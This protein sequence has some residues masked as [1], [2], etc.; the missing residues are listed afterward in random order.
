MTDDG[1]NWF[2]ELKQFAMGR[3]AKYPIVD[4]DELSA[5]QEVQCC[6]IG[7]SL[8]TWL[9]EHGPRLIQERAILA[10]LK[11]WEEDPFIVFT[12]EQPGLVAART[13]LGDGHDTVAFLY[14]DEFTEY[15]QTHPDY[16][17]RWHVHT[18]SIFAPLDDTAIEVDDYP[19]GFAESYWLHK[20]GTM[21]GE[22]FGRGGD[23]LWKWNGEEPVLLKECISQWI[24]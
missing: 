15:L 2:D 9:R 18:W 12:S 3:R 11:K 17:F 14:P 24:S 23:H 8:L 16:E 22:S 20:E 19:I 6:I 1:K 4:R 13:I 5:E 10:N 7:T 21:C